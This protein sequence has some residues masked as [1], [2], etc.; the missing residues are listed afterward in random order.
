MFII[1]Y[2]LMAAAF[3]VVIIDDAIVDAQIKAIE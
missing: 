3:V 1:V 2:A